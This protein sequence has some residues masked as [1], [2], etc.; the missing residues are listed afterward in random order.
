M[1]KF[2]GCVTLVV[3]LVLSLLV[4]PV[5]AQAPPVDLISAPAGS[6]LTNCGTP[7]S[8]SLCLVSSGVYAWQNATQGWFLLA[9]AVAS[10]GVQKVNGVAPGSTGNVTLSCP[11]TTPVTAVSVTPVISA[12][13]ATATV[14]ASGSVPSMVVTNTCTATGS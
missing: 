14:T 8:P 12:S 1:K 7:T 5:P 4:L 9:P 11:G 13:G 3:M 2:I 6:T 10:A